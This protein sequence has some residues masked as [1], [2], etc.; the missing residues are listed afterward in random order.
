MKN[1]I[2]IIAAIGKNNE[3][4]KNNDLIWD[5]PG[6][7]RRF[8]ELTSG[9][10]VIMG[11]KTFESMSKNP[12]PNRTNI[13][14]ALEENVAGEVEVARSV[15]EAVEIAQKSK[16]SEKIF[17]IGGGMIYKLFLPIANTLNLT[18]VNEEDN[19]ADVFFPTFDINQ[20]TKISREERKVDGLEFAFVELR[21][22]NLV[23]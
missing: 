23:I 2:I 9:H 13:I 21:R 10:P 17:V 5:I 19:D 16:G 1:E 6:D 12:L 7:L 8:K 3:L 4:G 22:K 11:Y 20:Y 18:M 15:N 14:M